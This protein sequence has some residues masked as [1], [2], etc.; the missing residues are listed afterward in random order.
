MLRSNAISCSVLL[1]LYS[2]VV[3]AYQQPPP[4]NPG[5]QQGYPP[6]GYQGGYHQAAGG[7]YTGYQAAGYQPV[8]AQQSTTNVVVVGSQPTVS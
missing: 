4:Y 8:P 2:L 3:M 1:P 7:A 5:Y 6:S